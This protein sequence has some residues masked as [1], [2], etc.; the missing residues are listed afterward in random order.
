M[1]LLRILVL[2]LAAAFA[3]VP[4]IAEEKLVEAPATAVFAGG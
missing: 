3:V 1:S 4:A 2:G